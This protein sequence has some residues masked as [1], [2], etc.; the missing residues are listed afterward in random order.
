MDIMEKYPDKDWDWWEISYKSKYHDGNN[1]KVSKNLGG[2]SMRV[3]RN[4]N[5]TME[6]EKS[7]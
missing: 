4:P 1:R 7:F 3:S 6:I 5:I 2:W